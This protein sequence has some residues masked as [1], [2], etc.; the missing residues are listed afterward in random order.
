MFTGLIEEVGEIV[1][2]RQTD[3]GREL[4][5]RSA[6]NDLVD[7][8]SIAVNGACLTVREHGDDWFTT[9]A[10]TTTLDR[11]TIGEW[12][13]GTRVN[14]ER[15][16]RASDRLG[17]HIVQGHVDF[18]SRVS[19]VLRAG[20]ALLID[21]EIPRSFEPLF[22]LHGSIAV[23]GV[24]LTVNAILPHG[25][26]LSLI[27]YTLRHTTLGDL[28]AGARVHVEADV[29]AKHVRKL[30]E[31]FLREQSTLDSLADFSLEH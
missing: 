27:E 23:D 26:Q 24:S 1:G 2:V 6:F 5:I 8:E 10:V 9:A 16:L 25:L 17:G 29:V 30:M 19:R 4:R 13:Q 22:V 14:L 20:D 3:A 28:T 12:K 7:G 15:S 21:L 18:V 31:P 11:T